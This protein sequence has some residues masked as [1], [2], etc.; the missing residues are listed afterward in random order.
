MM[1]DRFGWSGGRGGHA[2][3]VQDTVKKAVITQFVWSFH[4][5]MG[6]KVLVG[7]EQDLLPATPTTVVTTSKITGSRFLLLCLIIIK[8]RAA[9]WGSCNV[10]CHNARQ[11]GKP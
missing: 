4:Q 10:C 1:M 5:V 3:E 7:V 2:K 11:D 9:G 8:M 6:A